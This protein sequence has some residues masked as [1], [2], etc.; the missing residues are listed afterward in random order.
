MKKRIISGLLSAVMALNIISILPGDAFALTSE[1]RIYEKDGY[2]V[3]YRIGSEWDNNRSV[4]VSIKNTG[5]ESILNWALKYDVG[6]EVYNLWNS[7]VYDSSEEYTIIKNNGYNYEI[8]PGQSA[9]YGYIVKGEETVIPEDIELCSRR[10]DVKSGYEVDFN[11]TSDWYT[12]FN[13]EIN[14][15][16]TSDEPIEAWTLSFDSNF[17]INNI[18]DA[19][20]LTSENRSYEVANQ[21]WTTPILAGES[22][23][24]G[25]SADKSATENASAENFVLTAVVVGKSALEYPDFDDIDYELDSDSDG[26]PDYY[27]DI[28][29]TDKNDPDTDGDGLTDGYEVFYL[30]TDSLKADSDDNGVNDGDEDPDNDGLSNLKEYE[31]GTDPHNAD[32]DG[33]GL[34]DGDEVNIHG[35]D[36]LKYDTDD[37]GI[38]DGDEI[39]LGLDPNNGSTNGTPDCERTFTQT[40][41]ADSEV[42]SAI[43]ETEGNPFRV[44]LEMEAAGVAE[45]NVYAR[46][47]GYSDAI[48]NSAIIGVAPE[49]AYTEG[50]T[51]EEVTVKF[52]LDNSI[53]DNTL[54]TYAETGNEFDGIKRLNVFMFIEDVNMLLPVETFHDAATNTVYTKTDRMGTFCLMDM[55][56]FAD[57]LDSALNKS[58][59]A[60]VSEAMSQ[61]M[62]DES[63]YISCSVEKYNAK[64]SAP[65]EK[66]QVIDNF[67]VVFMIDCRNVVDP[68]EYAVIQKNIIE[69]ADTVLIKSPNA[70]IKIVLMFSVKASLE[71]GKA[72][73]VLRMSD[74]KGVAPNDNTEYFT[75]IDDIYDALAKASELVSDGS[76]CNISDAINSVYSIAKYSGRKTYC[77]SIF[78]SKN[79]FYQSKND[80]GYTALHDIQDNSLPINISAVC[81]KYDDQIY[82]YAID[83]CLMTGGF[84]GNHYENSSANMISHIY[85]DG[86]EVKNGY[87]AIIATGYKTVQLNASLQQNYEWYRKNEKVDPYNPLMDTDKD[88]LADYQEIMFENYF[89]NY[90][91]RRSLIDDTDPDN[92]KLL[93]Y[94][95]IVDILGDKY[96]YVE[97]GLERYRSATGEAAW[98]PRSLLDSYILPI[99]SDPTD[100]NGD[101]DGISDAL[102]GTPLY[103]AMMPELFENLV[104][105]KLVK[106]DDISK[107]DDELS[108]CT[109]SYADILSNV[110]SL[111]E[112]KLLMYDYSITAAELKEIE[113]VTQASYIVGYTIIDTTFYSVMTVEKL[114]DKY[115]F[116]D[117]YTIKYNVRSNS[118]DYAKIVNEVDGYDF[119]YAVRDN[120]KD[121]EAFLGE[122]VSASVDSLF[123]NDFI[124]TIRDRM[125]EFQYKKAA[126]TYLDI[127]DLPNAIKRGSIKGGIMA[128]A[129]KPM[130]A[131]HAFSL[132]ADTL[133][134]DYLYRQ[135]YYNKYGTYPSSLSPLR[136]FFVCGFEMFRDMGSMIIGDT[137][138]SFVNDDGSF[139]IE[140]SGEFFGMI[141]GGAAVTAMG[142]ISVEDFAN[143]VKDTFSKPK[144]QLSSADSVYKKLYET[145]GTKP[146]E[147]GEIDNYQ[148]YIP[149][150][151]N[152]IF[153]EIRIGEKT[154]KISILREN[155]AVF[156]KIASLNNAKAN[157]LMRIFEYT[158]LNDILKLGKDNPTEF[159]RKFVEAADPK[160]PAKI[161][162]TT[163]ST[164][165]HTDILVSYID[166]Y[167]AEFVDILLKSDER[168]VTNTNVYGTEFVD[169]VLKNLKYSDDIITLT[170]EFGSGFIHDILDSSSESIGKSI[171]LKLL[172]SYRRVLKGENVKAL[173]KVC[174]AFDSADPLKR[175]MSVNGS[176]FKN[177]RLLSTDE[178]SL[179]ADEILNNMYKSKYGE[180]AFDNMT[181]YTD[182]YNLSMSKEYLN[183]LP[184]SYFKEKGI[185]RLSVEKQMAKLRDAIGNTKNEAIQNNKYTNIPDSTGQSIKK[186][187]FQENWQVENCA[188][189]W[190]VRQAIMNG[191]EWKNISFRCIN[192]E[193]G[194]YWK[195]CANCKE[196]FKELIT[197]QGEK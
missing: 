12:G 143:N 116:H 95:Q 68:D 128:V 57:N 32:T 168:F 28:L 183:K 118:I 36:P 48:A 91:V 72:Y 107:A 171:N 127:L 137:Y 70:R 21:L 7:K 178:I 149:S 169:V 35:T 13:G 39:A 8:E 115:S 40:V 190:S 38:S 34:T 84:C 119:A 97:N 33:D 80:D 61:N 122:I 124:K 96:F 3:T 101:K 76:N 161:L 105:Y 81:D 94:S 26:L 140:G 75:D 59:E 11:V 148:T 64:A 174:V 111:P 99:R 82:G 19:K 45:N 166:R 156:D 144:T 110:R 179:G 62:S 85:F 65:D 146:A 16:N 167:G 44:S 54:G 4:E 145:N 160:N 14:I 139:N 154:T 150:E 77:F 129:F 138:S 185:N 177:N 147:S 151:K 114:K 86:G 23:S 63:G 112:F 173:N 191:A 66:N 192:I 41:S 46:K 56:I 113:N 186:P 181:D 172:E 182:Y 175:G 123:G 27:E 158:R 2:T 74:I 126:C 73:R 162:S 131:S 22:A 130:I 132:S 1:S 153:K 37:D 135:A 90:A 79:V 120:A 25:F 109:L 30:G 134:Y 117:I 184:D 10:I 58:A 49:F 5:E 69:T 142:Q 17:D 20:L 133:E 15:T 24:F 180:E 52:E 83:M 29:G 89:D 125:P 50:L 121:K 170:S 98:N 87:K 104:E 18:W 165:T 6:G 88:G 47:S 189:I 108:I 136:S 92:V 141:V 42:L 9:N 159:A 164:L 197:E 71:N 155:E 152:E 43:N 55:E 194:V 163:G 102:D 196:T 93:T 51:V 103:N 157:R 188:E 67:D 53:V 106:Y 31:L 187:S 195:P 176:Y 60:E 78:K 193:D 100:K